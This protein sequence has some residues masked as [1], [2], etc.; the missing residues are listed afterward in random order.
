MA[1]TNAQVTAITDSIAKAIT[2]FNTNFLTGT[3]TITTTINSGVGGTGATSATLG[4]VLAYAAVPDAADELALL[5]KVNTVA[6]NV[7]AYLTGVRALNSLYLQYLPLLDALDTTQSG[8]NAFLTSNA[9]QVNAFAAAAFN[10]Y[11]A[12]ATT[13]GF[14]TPAN[15]PVAIATANFFPYAAV[16]TLWGF[17]CSG[18]TTFSANAVG[19]NV[20]T[21]VSGGG[22]GQVY[23]YKN[24]ATNAIGCATFTITYTNAAGTPATA[25]YS[26]VSGTPT[27][28][29]SLSAG[30][31]RSRAIAQAIT[32][33]SGTGM[34]NAEQYTLGIQL[35]RTA[36]Y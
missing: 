9:L 25:T 15:I 21:A 1:L 16:D 12:N 33:V 4:R 22:V 8:L 11:Q 6:S 2:D 13:L 24:N 29:G 36:A 27:A 34:T 31:A 28:T 10:Y 19:T 35:V 7:A 3:A 14:R 17:T 30:L 18:A 20:S 32:A 26:T 5:P 23:I